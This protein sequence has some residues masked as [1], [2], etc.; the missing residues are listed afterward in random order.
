MQLQVA[1]EELLGDSCAVGLQAVP[2]QDGRAGQLLAEH[3]KETDHG[4]RVDVGVGVKTEIELYCV[5]RGRNTERGDHRHFLVGSRALPENRRFTTR[6]PRPPHQRR[7]Q[8]AA[9]I[10]ENEPCLQ[11]RGFFLMRGQCVLTQPSMKSS[12]RST[13]RRAGF[14]GLQP[15][16]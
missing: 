13:A 12:S 10:D 9:L 6:A 2:D 15:K 1:R 3:T 7:H 11:A 5:A 16:E 4:L 14:W 8:Y